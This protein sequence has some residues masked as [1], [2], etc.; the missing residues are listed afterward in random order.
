MNKLI[1]QSIIA[2]LFLFGCLPATAHPTLAPTPTVE[3]CTDRGWAD[4]TS[5]LYEYDKEL[6]EADPNADAGILVGKLEK[7]MA[8][9]KEVGI[10]GCT[11]NARRSLISGMENRILGI[12]Y[13]AAGENDSARVFM[14]Y[15]FRWIIAARDELKYYGI[16]L[17]Y[18][19]Q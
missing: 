17:K 3:Q 1:M 15:S 8:N 9:I 13:M 18:P 2:S 11:E 5:Y 6:N 14:N 12:N 19:V 7:I 16:D 4:I 10:D